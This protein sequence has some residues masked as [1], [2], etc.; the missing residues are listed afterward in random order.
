[1]LRGWLFVPDWLFGFDDDG[2][3]VISDALLGSNVVKLLVVVFARTLAK[4][5]R[6]CYIISFEVFMHRFSWIFLT[7]YAYCKIHPDCLLSIVIGKFVSFGINSMNIAFIIP[8]CAIASKYRFFVHGGCEL[9]RGHLVLVPF[10]GAVVFDENL[11]PITGCIPSVT[12]SLDIFY[13]SLKCHNKIPPYKFE[14]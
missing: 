1:M 10:P 6:V 7:G 2:I 5:R 12:I 9:F 14:C 8:H 13:Q 4:T 3:L 11:A